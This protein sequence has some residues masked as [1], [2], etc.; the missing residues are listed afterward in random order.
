MNTS[1]HRSKHG[2]S[3]IELLVAIGV[4]ALLIGIL[5][6]VLAKSREAGKA[7]VC[8][9][10]MRSMASATTGYMLDNQ[11]YYP[12]PSTDDGINAAGSDAN[13]ALWYNA[14]DYYVGNEVK[15][16][17]SGDRNDN[18][19]K[20]DP[21]WLDLPANGLDPDNA[22]TIKMN[23]FFGWISSSTT[24]PSATGV[25]PFKFFKATRIQQPSKTV[26][27]G[28]GRAHDTPSATTGNVDTGGA[29]LFAL[30]G[31]YVGL[32][33]QEGAN[34]VMADVSVSHHS[35]PVRQTGSG[36]QGWYENSEA[37]AILRP[38]VIFDFDNRSTQ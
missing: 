11:Q 18:A 15:A 23:E 28:D 1:Y 36:Y 30:R 13:K 9:S 31:V 25:N 5:L 3:L 7:V 32:R 26:L 20:Q 16:G 33:H 24:A 35:N 37:N 4:I 27:F 22:R 2:F 34:L 14:L 19:Y 38:D 8:M 12:Q 21:V 6:P 17:G 10:N 29:G